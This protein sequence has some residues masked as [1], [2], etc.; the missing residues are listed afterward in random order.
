MSRFFVS[1]AIVLLVFDN[2]FEAVGRC[3]CGAIDAPHHEE[4]GTF[5]VSNRV[6][7]HGLETLGS[8]SEHCMGAGSSLNDCL[9]D[10][11]N[12]GRDTKGNSHSY[13]EVSC[14]LF[15]QVG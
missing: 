2:G 13:Q 9:V 8:G 7:G 6:S 5:D 14:K 4:K 15:A 3:V 10:N 11:C 12:K 1:L